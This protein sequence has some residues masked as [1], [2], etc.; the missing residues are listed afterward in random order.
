MESN[1]VLWGIV[2]LIFIIWLL[3]DGGIIEGI[4]NALLIIAVL[5]IVI[6]AMYS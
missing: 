4:F 2:G 1:N 3:S 6:F 5:N